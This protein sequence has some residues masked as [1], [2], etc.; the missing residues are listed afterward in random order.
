M[1]LVSNRLCPGNSDIDR[2]VGIRTQQ[3]TA[4]RSFAVAV[5]M[6]YL[7][8]GMHAGIGTAGANNFDGF[9]GNTAERGLN[10]RLNSI[11]RALPLPA[12]IRGSV[13]LNA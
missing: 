6:H 13:V 10:V 11:A 8:G 1:K 9:V 5:K 4:L 12:V 2:K 3:P 7:T